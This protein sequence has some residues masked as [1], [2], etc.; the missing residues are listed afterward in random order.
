MYDWSAENMKKLSS[1]I[2]LIMSHAL[3]PEM[4]AQL[5]TKVV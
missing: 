2:Y 1:Q 4:V 3:R 5:Q